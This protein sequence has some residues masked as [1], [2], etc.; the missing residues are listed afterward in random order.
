MATIQGIYVALFG[1]PADPTGLAFFNAATNNGADLTAIGDLASTAEYQDRFEGMNN[2]QIIRSIYQSLF[3]RDPEEAGLNFFTA[4]LNDGSLNINNIAIGILDGA[5]NEDRTIVDAKI[6]SANLFTASLDTPIEIASYVGETA[7]AQGRAFL[8]D[9]GTTPKTQAQADAAVA[10]MVSAGAAGNTITLSAGATVLDNTTA[11]NA[12]KVTTSNNDTINTTHTNWVPGTSTIDGGFGVD[13]FNLTE[14]E[15]A[16]VIADG[17]KNIEIF[18]I[19]VDAALP[20]I[21]NVDN[22]KQL[23]QVW[24]NASAN[25][26]TVTDVALA[27]TV[28]LKG[29]LGGNDTTFTFKGAGGTADSASLALNGATNAGAVVIADIETLNV[30]NTGTSNVTTLDA[31]AAK[32]VNLTGS[33]SLTLGFTSTVLETLDASAFAGS[34][35]VDVQNQANITSVLGGSGSDSITVDTNSTK[36]LT[37]NGGAGADTLTVLD[38]GV[39]TKAITLIGGD[40][41]DIFEIGASGAYVANADGTT[42]TTLN[43]SL[44]IISDFGNG[45][46]AIK[47]GAAA[48]D[49]LLDAELAAIEGQLTL[50]AAASKAAE[51]TAD[52]NAS[53]FNYK[54]DAYILINDADQAFD[55]GEGLVKVTGAS[56]ADFDATNFQIVV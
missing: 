20:A 19:T 39:A 7:A 12:D 22:A 27:T 41:A 26:L 40:G 51:F 54:G 8:A 56:V 28:G 46:D 37:V 44:I 2:A 36:A 49:V 16:T 4:A 35:T 30:S 24:N 18:N 48:R 32:T 5:Q 25:N 9:V 47:V 15:S 33:G 29:N 23:T 38:N 50:F 17:L 43:N 34:L 14:A 52:N 42:A 11:T 3:N 55:G 21:I 6:E 13:T 53:I 31:D 45:N 1:R 10:A